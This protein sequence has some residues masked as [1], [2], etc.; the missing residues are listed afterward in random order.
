MQTDEQDKK[1]LLLSFIDIL[2]GYFWIKWLN[3]NSFT[4]F[5][6]G[7]RG[8]G[9]CKK[10]LF[11]LVY[12]IICCHKYFGCCKFCLKLNLLSLKLGHLQLLVSWLFVLFCYQASK[13]PPVLVQLLCDELKIQPEQMLDFELCLADTQPAVSDGNQFYI[14]VYIMFFIVFITYM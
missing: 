10:V 1:L 6:M 2:S 7:G 14:Y 12:L 3:R 9:I 4:L 5:F 8:F 13:H 11:F